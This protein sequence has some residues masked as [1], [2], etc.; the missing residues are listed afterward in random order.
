MGAGDG[1]ESAYVA[2]VANTGQ[3]I[4]QVGPRDQAASAIR[5]KAHLSTTSEAPDF[6]ETCCQL[7]RFVRETIRIGARGEFENEQSAVTRISGDSC[8]VQTV[9]KPKLCSLGANHAAKAVSFLLQGTDH[10][11]PADHAIGGPREL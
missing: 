10:S 5:D 9:A 1:D 3:S 7:Q 11:I 4:L 8:C 2:S 6:L